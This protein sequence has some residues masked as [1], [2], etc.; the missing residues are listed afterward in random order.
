[1]DKLLIGLYIIVSIFVVISFIYISYRNKKLYRK[2]SDKGLKVRYS[3][4]ADMY[5]VVGLF[6]ILFVLPFFYVEKKNFTDSFIENPATLMFLLFLLIGFGFLFYGIY[7]YIKEKR[8]S[9]NLIIEKKEILSGGVLKGKIIY[10]GINIK[11]RKPVKIH[12]ILQKVY[13][14]SNRETEIGEKAIWSQ[15]V[16][17]YPYIFQNYMEIPFEFDIKEDFPE[18]WEEDYELVLVV[19]DENIGVDTFVLE[20]KGKAVEDITLDELLEEPISKDSKTSR[21]II[22]QNRVKNPILNIIS[23]LFVIIFP[24]FFWFLLRYRGQTIKEIE[25]QIFY[26]LIYGLLIILLFFLPLYFYLKSINKSKPEE[27][28]RKIRIFTNFLYGIV[29]VSFL[30]S[31]FLI[32]KFLMGDTKIIDHLLDITTNHIIDGFLGMFFILGIYSLLSYIRSL[33]SYK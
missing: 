31:G 5:I 4:N 10:S 16:E 15:T 24:A 2:L 8:I 3:K 26:T 32:F 6:T 22:V 17:N 20:S 19:E 14:I 33:T 27:K 28:K 18:D 11:E 30:F 9:K 23:I 1:M 13:I 7:A 12:L 21:D 25:L 29:F